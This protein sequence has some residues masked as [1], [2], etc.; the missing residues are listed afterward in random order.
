MDLTIKQLISSN[1]SNNV[2]LLFYANKQVESDG[3]ACHTKRLTSEQQVC[4]GGHTRWLFNDYNKTNLKN[5][6]THSLSFLM[7]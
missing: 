5:N 4:G 1:C 3:T 6:Y 7:Y 2:D